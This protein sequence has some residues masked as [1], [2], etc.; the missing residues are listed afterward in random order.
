MG[1]RAQQLAQELDEA[2]QELIGV[3]ERC[4]DTDWTR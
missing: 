1:H 2:V 4:S 3:V